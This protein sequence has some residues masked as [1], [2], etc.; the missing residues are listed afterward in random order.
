MISV[1]NNEGVRF[2]DLL[3]QHISG[4]AQSSL[5]HSSANKLLAPQEDEAGIAEATR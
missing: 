4:V 5:R 2:A 3:S 1:N